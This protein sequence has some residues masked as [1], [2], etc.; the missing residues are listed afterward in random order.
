[1]PLEI[2]NC[3]VEDAST[4]NS[5]TSNLDDVSDNGCANFVRRIQTAMDSSWRKHGSLIRSIFLVIL[6]LLYGAYFILA[7]SYSFGDESSIRLLGITCVAVVGCLIKFFSKLSYSKQIL[8]MFQPTWQ[9]IGKHG[10]I[11][12]W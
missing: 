11:I 12:N 7:M 2:N 1:M 10:N 3:N 8:L 9:K 6:L 4:E 5:K